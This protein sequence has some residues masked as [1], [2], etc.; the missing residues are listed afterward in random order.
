MPPTTLDQALLD[1]VAARR[2]LIDH[3]V[4]FI[5]AHPELAHEEHICSAHLQQTF[6]MLGLDVE[7]GLG[8]METGFRATLQGR[9]P[10]RAVGIVTLYDAVASV[11]PTGGFAAVHSCGHGQISGGVVGALAALATV[12]DELPGR[13]VVMGCP[14]DEIHAPGTVARGSG[15]TISADAGAWDDIDAALYAHPEPVDT[16]WSETAWMRRDTAIVAGTR[17]LDDSAAQPVLASVVAAVNAA[18][19]HRRSTVMLE[20]VTLDGD[21]EEGGGLVARAR[22]LIWS[23][24]EAGLGTLA[25]QLRVA[26]PADWSEGPV[27]PGIVADAYVTEMVFDALRATGRSPDEDPGP[28]PFATDFG[29]VTHRVPGSLVGVGRVGGWAFHT[30]VGEQ[31]FASDEGI[32]AATDIAQVLALAAIRLAAPR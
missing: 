31:Q 23:M 9:R 22:F 30:P 13:I 20:H 21:V 8:G 1:A 4:R 14:A 5:T 12:R 6:A 25:D 2:P 10:G 32:A 3:T 29:S 27:V 7:A 17:L 19:A 18:A 26:L 28:L 11:P 15:K 16:A 24:D